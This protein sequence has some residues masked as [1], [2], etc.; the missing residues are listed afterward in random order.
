MH[1]LLVGLLIVA[2]AMTV[3]L[4]A[5]HTSTIQGAKGSIKFSAREPHDLYEP[6]VEAVYAGTPDEASRLLAD[7]CSGWYGAFA[8]LSKYWH[9][10][11]LTMTETDGA[12]FGYWALE[13]AAIAYL[14]DIDDSAVDHMV[15]PRDLIEYARAFDISQAN[16][17]GEVN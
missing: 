14:Y 17:A 11:H 10:T 1:R 6:L 5:E 15:Y 9:D 2:P 7:Y 12:Y 16:A 8:N 13:A 4:A 3:C